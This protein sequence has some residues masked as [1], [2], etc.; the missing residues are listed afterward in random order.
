[1]KE[2]VLVID[3]EPDVRLVV[4]L[5]LVRLGYE[6]A[7]A[8]DGLEGLRLFEEFHPALVI[9]DLFM[10]RCEGIE[11]IRAIRD[12]GHPAT[13]IAMSGAGTSI[14]FLQHALELGA[15]A[16]IAKPFGLKELSD[17]IAKALPQS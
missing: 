11:T 1:M 16:A 17:T 2:R 10:P 5:L 12:Q 14:N 15:D 13:V 6:V 9:T 4:Q 8:G 7:S 3:D